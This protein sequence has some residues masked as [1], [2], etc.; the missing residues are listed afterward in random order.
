MAKGSISV[1]LDTDLIAW[2]DKQVELKKYQSR[3]HAIR[4][5]IENLKKKS[6][7]EP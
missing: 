5:A 1:S 7:G 6:G 3:S 4:K 2:V